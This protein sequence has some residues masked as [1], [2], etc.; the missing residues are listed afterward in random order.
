MAP[1]KQ[2]AETSTYK[3]L[4]SLFYKTHVYSGKACEYLIPIHIGA[5]GDHMLI[6]RHSILRRISPFSK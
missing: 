4:A 3:S 2:K 1:E 6:K 5:V